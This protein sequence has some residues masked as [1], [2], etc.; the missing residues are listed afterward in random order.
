MLLDADF[1]PYLKL[2]A[3]AILLMKACLKREKIDIYEIIKDLNICFRTLFLYL[4]GRQE[5]LLKEQ[6]DSNAALALKKFN[7]QMAV[8]TSIHH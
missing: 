6:D 2:C 8:R 5:R 4:M 3:I 7:H 1:V